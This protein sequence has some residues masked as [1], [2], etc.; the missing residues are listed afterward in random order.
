MKNSNLRNEKERE[1][2]KKVN[3]L[4]ARITHSLDIHARL[5]FKEALKQ[6]ILE[7]RHKTSMSFSFSWFHGF[8]P[9]LVGGGFAALIAVIIVMLVF[10]PFLQT[11]PVVYAQDNFVLTAESEDSLGIE[12]SSSF[13]IESKD[14]IQMDF[15]KK[16]LSA[17]I[18]I[19]FELE[20]IDDHS[21]RITFEKHLNQSQMVRFILPTQIS[22]S[23]GSVRER[24]YSWAFQ[25]KK[26]FQVLY[27]IPGNQTS[28]VPLGSGIEVVFSHENVST[29]DFEKAFSITPAVKGH[30]EKNRRSVVFIPDALTAGTIY[31]VRIASSLTPESSF[32]TLAKDFT[33]KFETDNELRRGSW[34]RFFDH[35]VTVTPLEKPELKMSTEDYYYATQSLENVSLKVYQFPTY[36][37]FRKS[38]LESLIGRWRFNRSFTEYVNLSSLNLVGTFSPEIVDSDSGQIHRLPVGL[39]EG[40]YGVVASFEGHDDWIFIQSVS[41]G[42]TVV[43][44]DE[45]SSLV[46]AND[47]KTKQPLVGAKVSGIRI[48]SYEEKTFETSSAE[49]TGADGI[50]RIYFAVDAEISEIISDDRSI[51]ILLESNVG[52]W[53]DWWWE[54]SYI[55]VNDN[56]WGYLYTDR[57]VY[58]AGDTVRVWGF[59][60]PRDNQPLPTT[61]KIKLTSSVYGYNS[62]YGYGLGDDVEYV[63]NEVSV[64]RD[65]IFINEFVLPNVSSAYFSLSVEFGDVSVLSRSIQVQEYRKPVYSL[66][67]SID[68]KAA[69]IGESVGFS[70]SATYFDGTP[71]AQKT[72]EVGTWY[73][74]IS[75]TLSDYG[76]ASGTIILTSENGNY[77]HA[78]L[79]EPGLEPV[80]TYE[81]LTIYPSSVLVF[82][83]TEI[84]ND[85]ATAAIDTRLVQISDS[86]NREDD[87]KN[88]SP[89]TSVKV[90]ATEIYYEKISQGNSYDFVRKIVRE[91]FTY[92]R[93]E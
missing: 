32:E 16:Y 40:Y 44:T 50:A 30:V 46:W 33:F 80:E 12:P 77:I 1:T 10:G 5:G 60:K 61:A 91:N 42:A 58:K 72:V 28:R 52:G 23:D 9:K 76:T 48:V 35:D 63:S 68:K 29:S 79:S 39:D 49:M 54:S 74:E 26:D 75:V 11:V 41:V 90:N 85:I 21:A 24:P 27:T 73:S 65:G 13:I 19:K 93:R 83:D 17:D 43:L 82:G 31:E 59:T 2:L 64:S 3:E 88:V 92:E 89:N 78:Q 18:D 25:V 56:Y 84:E 37:T 55:D 70:V 14:E 22:D 87:Y 67:L 57:T 81:S 53:R 34:I 66:D 71:V 86:D 8:V 20:K 62:S 45:D 36:E 4:F 15:L 6:R 7:A 38:F 51:L 69:I 47:T